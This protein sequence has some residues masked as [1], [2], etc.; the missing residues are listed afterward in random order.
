MN[1]TAMT[2]AT[3]WTSLVLSLASIIIICILQDRYK[4]NGL[5]RWI[6]NLLR[7]L[8]GNVGPWASIMYQFNVITPQGQIW[9]FIIWIGLFLIAVA[10]VMWR[11]RTAS[12]HLMSDK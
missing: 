8:I 3:A 12:H 11:T 7:F 9:L 5:Q 4:A 10:A 2:F 6:D 1:Q